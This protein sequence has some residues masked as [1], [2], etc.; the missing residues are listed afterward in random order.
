MIMRLPTGVILMHDEKIQAAQ[1]EINAIL[2]RL[3][4]D[5]KAER[6]TILNYTGTQLDKPDVR[7]ELEPEKQRRMLR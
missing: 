3:C 5:T 4:K 7:I 2:E 1:N 6:M